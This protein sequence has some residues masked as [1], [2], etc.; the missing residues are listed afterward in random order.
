MTIKVN[1]MPETER[2]S[3]SILCGHIERQLSLA[4]E[5]AKQLPGLERSKKEARQ[6]CSYIEGAIS[7]AKHYLSRL[8]YLIE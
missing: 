4:L 6:R 8:G 2:Y 7:S 1:G 5:D 3:Y